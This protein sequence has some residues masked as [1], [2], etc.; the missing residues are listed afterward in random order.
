MSATLPQ[1][2]ASRLRLALLVSL[3][4]NV[5]LAGFIA[6]HHLA[7]RGHAGPHDANGHS[8]DNMFEHAAEGLSEPDAA[9]LRQAFLAHRS[10]LE[11]AQRSYIADAEAVR[12]ALAAEPFDAARLR[13][14]MEAARIAR[15]QLGPLIETVTLEAAP[16]MSAAGRQ[17][18]ARHHR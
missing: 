1:R 14:G 7:H 3:G 13:A 16:H 9:A 8:V 4:M 11:A 17:E 2:P 10:E 12:A 15:Q 5:L 18:L 6:A